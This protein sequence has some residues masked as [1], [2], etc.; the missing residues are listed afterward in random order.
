MQALS[1]ERAPSPRSIRCVRQW[2]CLPA[3]R[4]DGMPGWGAERALAAI[5]G[6]SYARA[7]KTPK[8]DEQMAMLPFACYSS[9]TPPSTEIIMERL[10]HDWHI[11]HWFLYI[12]VGFL[13]QVVI[14]AIMSGISAVMLAHRSEGSSRDVFR[15]AY[16]RSFLG[17]HPD[18]KE[19]KKSD[20]LLPFLLGLLEL[21]SYPVLMATGA[22]TAIGAWLGFKTL[23]QWKSWG[24]DRVTFNHYLIGNALVL[25]SSL[26][27]LV[28]FVTVTPPGCAQ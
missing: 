16:Y 24:D 23:A 3:R 13:L 9:D 6:Q 28:Y 20:C 10:A 4:P 7:E 2:L 5:V 22:W 17:F 12:V 25:L 19:N 11:P 15:G 14:R 8:S 21:Y 18:D 26:L 27:F 1:C